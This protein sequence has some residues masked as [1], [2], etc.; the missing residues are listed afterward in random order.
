MRLVSTVWMLVGLLA[1][2]GTLRAADQ[3]NPPRANV[4]RTPRCP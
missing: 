2:G 3:E 4:N 1:I